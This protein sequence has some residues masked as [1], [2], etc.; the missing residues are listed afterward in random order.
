MKTG[1]TSVQLGAHRRRKA[2]LENGV[3]YPGNAPNQRRPLGALMG[4]AVNTWSRRRPLGPDLLDRDDVNGIPPASDWT[5]L[6][7]EI[8]ADQER[9]IF[10]THEFVSQVDDDTARRIVDAIGPRVHIA[11]TLRA[12]GQIVPSLWAQSV[13]DDAQIEPYDRWIERFFGRVPDQPL[14]PRYQ[15]AYQQADL[16]DRW[17]RLV[18]P[19]KVTV[20]IVDKTRPT[21]LTDTFEAMLGLPSGMLRVE[22]SNDSLM[23]VD[24][25]LFRR[26]NIIL[27]DRNALWT[28]FQ[29]LVWQG[30]IKLGPE[31]REVGADE[32]RVVLPPWAA[33]IAN[34]DGARFADA[35]RQSPVRVVGNVENLATKVGSAPWD[36]IDT[37]PIDIAAEAVA[38][39]VL[40]GQKARESLKK[41][42]A[43]LKAQVAKLS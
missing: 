4:W 17:S 26:V 33:Q 6:K 23:A 11:I 42:V 15:R 32:R 19:E 43:D 9:R 38:G 28:T 10:L 22:R 12:P 5:S 36:P 39:A 18:G 21:L 3:R 13:R 1:T 7:E 30:A 24:A 14:S 16:V 41:E 27:R 25:E 2:L 29:A 34:A 8:D 37:V 31:R 20:T 35:L 40:A